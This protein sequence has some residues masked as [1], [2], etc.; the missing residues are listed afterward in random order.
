MDA[1]RQ[2]T[3]HV[4]LIRP[5]N[6]GPNTETAG[7]NFFQREPSESTAD[8]QGWA[9]AE[10]DRL[11][12]ALR[13]AGVNPI[14]FEDTDSP[15]KPDAIFPNNWVSFHSDGRVF[16]YPMEAPS[17]RAERRMDI[18]ES[19][20][21]THGFCVA[22]IV[23]MSSWENG[24]VFLEGTGSIVLDRA[25][26]IAYAALSSRTHMSVLSDFAQQADYEI[27]G[28]EC[29]D[30]SGRAVYHTNVVMGIGREFAVI[31]AE[32]IVD[33][34]KRE[35]VLARLNASG[36]EIVEISIAQMEAFAGNLIE[37]DT[38]SNQSVIVL[39]RTAYDIMSNEQLDTLS[40]F[41]RLMPV[42]VDIIERVGGG[43]VRCMIAEVFLPAGGNPAMSNT[44]D[45]SDKV[46]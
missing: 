30:S 41:G 29:V 34:D 26:R 44:G 35:A 18:I 13:V 5:R 9:L 27:A 25:N 1:D 32:S 39:S 38:D 17:R 4:V 21:E 19:L 28:F 24:G 33:A 45:N 23:D 16:I 43:S 20:S 6:F 46:T 2:I 37:L 40:W 36:R 14:V 15:V 31:C 8:T 11:V 22:E 12:E 3:R 7:T 42:P 10:F